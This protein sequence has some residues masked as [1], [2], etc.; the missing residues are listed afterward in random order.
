MICK[1][2]GENIKG[3]IVKVVEHLGGCVPPTP[4]KRIT[5]ENVI[6]ELGKAWKYPPQK[7]LK[8]M[9]T[10]KELILTA[11]QHPNEETANKAMKELR[12]RF[13]KTYVWCNDCDGL[14]TKEKD[15]CLNID[16]STEDIIDWE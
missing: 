3:G 16:P 1:H 6:D 13:D 15:C 2:C 12:S 10:E 4:Y 11:E 14:V 5:S 9:K 8:A 7:L